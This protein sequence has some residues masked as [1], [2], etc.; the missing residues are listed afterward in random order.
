MAN[1]TSDKVADAAGN[2]KPYVER[3]IHDEEVRD[4]VKAAFQAAREVYDELIGNRSVSTVATR[5]ATD[6]EIQD[7]LREAVDELREASQRVQG[8]KDHGG[9]NAT[10][11]M[12]GIALGVLFNPV[13]GPATRKWIADTMFGGDEFTY[14]AGAN[15]GN[16]TPS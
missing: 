11:L 2:V 7:K 13:T 10:L 4:N 6:R 3:A 8:K 15:G 14:D 9:R 12:A 1:K 16:S 5:V